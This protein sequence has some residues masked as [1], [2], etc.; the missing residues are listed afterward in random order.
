MFLPYHCSHKNGINSW[1]A[2]LGTLLH[3]MYFCFQT[4]KIVL[5]RCSRIYQM[6][7]YIN[8]IRESAKGQ[9]WW[10]KEYF[11]SL[12]VNIYVVW[13]M[14][15]H[16]FNIL[17]GILCIICLYILLSKVCYFSGRYN[18][19]CQMGKFQTKNSNFG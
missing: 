10:E 16:N 9:H 5:C 3:K 19:G 14:Y 2:L 7:Q 17:L 18:Q 8:L 4:S 6:C 11:H 1:A 13:R 12:H 15:E